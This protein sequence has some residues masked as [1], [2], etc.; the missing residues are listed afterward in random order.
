MRII[1][2]L[3]FSVAFVAVLSCVSTAEV[4][5]AESENAFTATSPRRVLYKSQII[6]IRDTV[7]DDILCEGP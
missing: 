4:A 6:I 7:C 3:L 5:T 1:R 2:K